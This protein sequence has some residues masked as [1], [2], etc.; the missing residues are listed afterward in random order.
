MVTA[1]TTADISSTNKQAVV[2]NNIPNNAGQPTYRP[3]SIPF[4]EYLE[5]H[6]CAQRVSKHSTF[7]FTHSMLKDEDEE[8]LRPLNELCFVHGSG[9]SLTGHERTLFSYNVQAEALSALLLEHVG[10]PSIEGHR[11]NDFAQQLLELQDNGYLCALANGAMERVCGDG[12]P[13]S[14][15]EPGTTTDLTKEEE[16][17]L[18]EILTLFKFE[19][20]NIAPVG[21]K[22]RIDKIKAG[23]HV[24]TLTQE[25][26]DKSPISFVYYKRG[27]T[28]G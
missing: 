25:Q 10:F 12:I 14:H 28:Q 11:D 19:P 7:I 13:G 20:N 17:A 15:L 22:K 18:S 24:A 1:G 9:H 2:Y 6:N 23:T 4:T 3:L 8:E 27:R 21:L 26:I 5:H 16:R